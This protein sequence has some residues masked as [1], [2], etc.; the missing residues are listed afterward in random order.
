MQDKK[1]FFRNFLIQL[2]VKF[3]NKILKNIDRSKN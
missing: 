2:F 3:E 1:H